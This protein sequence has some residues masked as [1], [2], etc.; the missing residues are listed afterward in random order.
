MQVK[1]LNNY[2]Y[3]LSAAN[4]CTVLIE[5]LVTI[6]FQCFV[7]MQIF[8]YACL[9]GNHSVTVNKVITILKNPSQGSHAICQHCIP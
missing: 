9:H 8:G 3:G 4:A 7:I 1:G 2:V 5:Q 6:E